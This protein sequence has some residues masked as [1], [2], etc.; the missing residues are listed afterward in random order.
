MTRIA[1]AV[2]SGF[3]LALAVHDL[4]RGNS[5]A[6]GLNVAASAGWLLWAISSKPS[7]EAKR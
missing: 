3:W 4:A 1:F 6:A 7:K 5:L 2:T